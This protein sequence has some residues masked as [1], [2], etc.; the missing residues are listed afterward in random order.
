MSVVTCMCSMYFSC[1]LAAMSCLQDS[2]LASLYRTANTR[3]CS[4]TEYSVTSSRAGL[5]LAINRTSDS[6]TFIIAD[7]MDS[8]NNIEL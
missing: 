5:L 2:V 6:I 3:P 8:H 4:S 7:I 1:H